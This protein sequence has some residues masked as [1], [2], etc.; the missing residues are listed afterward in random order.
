VSPSSLSGVHRSGVT[1]TVRASFW[2]DVLYCDHECGSAVLY[3]ASARNLSAHRVTRM[4]TVEEL[5]NRV[6]HF[7]A[8]GQQTPVSCRGNF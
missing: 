4:R 7:L 6:G 3:R 1:P 8:V 5:T 2:R